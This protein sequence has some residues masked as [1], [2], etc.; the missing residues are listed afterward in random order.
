MNSA[1]VFEQIE[2]MGQLPSLPQTLLHVQ[3][4]ASSDKSSAEDLAQ[5]ILKDQAL[6]M[7]VLKVVNSAM[8]QRRSSEKVRTVRK[9]VIVMGFETV[10]KL[11][12]GLSVFDMMSKLSRSPW[13]IHIANHSLVTAAFAQIL[14]EASGSARLEEAF[15]AALVHDIGKVVL[16]ECSPADMDEVFQDRAGGISALEAERRHFGITHD[17]AGRR[18]AA[19]WDL[20]P[21]IQNII[22]D[23]HDIDPLSPPR[24]LDPLLG[25]IVYANAISRFTGTPENQEMEFK[26]LRKAGRRLGIPSSKLDEVYGQVKSVVADLAECFGVEVGDLEEYHQIINVP[27]SS[28]VA[29]RCMTPDELARRTARQLELYQAIG[30]GLASGEDPGRLLDNIL[31]GAVRILG[32]ERVVLFRVNRTD[33]RLEAHLWAGIQADSLAPKLEFPLKRS[34]GA[35]VNVVLEHRAFHV[36]DAQSDAYGDLVGKGLLA[37]ADCKGFIATPVFNA[38]GLV[39]VIYADGGPDGDD[40]SAEQ[41]SELAGLATQAGLVLAAADPQ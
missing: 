14:A 10:R 29:P 15:V 12:L 11:A 1:D 27:G 5:C 4:V 23:H 41:A 25:T 7:R 40:V 18:L 17:R 33:Q 21:Q 9:A 28:N 30:M 38:A 13:L 16:L 31:Q 35:L 34:Y 26:I 32:F 22:G 8:Y 37:A 6:T 3:E 2:K 36:P 39:A 20:P 19:R 24:N